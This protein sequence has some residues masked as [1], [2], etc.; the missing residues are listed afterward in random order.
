MKSILYQLKKYCPPPED[1]IKLTVPEAALEQ[2]EDDL[3]KLAS[4]I[5]GSRDWT[6]SEVVWQADVK[7][8]ASMLA[9]MPDSPNVGVLFSRE[10]LGIYHCYW[11][12]HEQVTSEAATDAFFKEFLQQT[13]PKEYQRKFEEAVD[14]TA[15][16]LAVVRVMLATAADDNSLSVPGLF[17]NK[18][19]PGGTTST[20]FVYDATTP[21]KKEDKL[22]FEFREPAA[23]YLGIHSIAAAAN[24]QEQTTRYAT[25]DQVI[26]GRM[27]YLM[28]WSWNNRGD[29]QDVPLLE[30]P[31]KALSPPK[32][33]YLPA[34][35]ASNG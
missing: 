9:D 5:V 4:R 24:F 31:R 17:S 13:D 26:L 35:E 1:M 30:A 2:R 18:Y 8:V 28:F 27:G 34:P 14:E 23:K 6:T 16:K 22:P 21:H 29:R 25:L 20:G 10:I 12:H 3:W 7:R 15:K 11:N 33:I 19:Y 32:V